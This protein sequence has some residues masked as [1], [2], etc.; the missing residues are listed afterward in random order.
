MP[1]SKR[2]FGI[3]RR[4]ALMGAA[5]LCTFAASA[6]AAAVPQTL[7]HQGRLFDGKGDPISD[8]LDVTFAIYAG[9]ADAVPIWEET[10]TIA[11]ENGFFSVALGTDQALGSAID[12][13]ERYLGI[14]VG[15]DAEMTPRSVVESV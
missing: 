10:H 11:F 4:R 1:T 8:T 15:Q 6:S 13:S 9:P 14:K 7:M 2:S 12:G 5:A 3:S